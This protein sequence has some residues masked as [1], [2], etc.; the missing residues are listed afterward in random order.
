MIVTDLLEQP[1][2]KS[3]NFNKVATSCQQLVPN[4]LTSCNKPCEHNLLTACLQTCYKLRD[5]YVCISRWIIGVIRCLPGAL[6]LKKHCCPG[7]ALSSKQQFSCKHSSL[8]PF[9]K[10]ISRSLTD[11]HN[12][13]R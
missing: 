13:V 12:T 10:H 5:F 9:S 1:C 3:D 11:L 6:G 2:N 7:T 4:L 8:L